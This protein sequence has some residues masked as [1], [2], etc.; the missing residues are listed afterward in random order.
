MNNTSD[1]FIILPNTW[2]ASRS[3]QKNQM[4]W[5]L[6]TPPFTSGLKWLLMSGE[7][8]KLS[9]FPNLCLIQL[10]LCL[11]RCFIDSFEFNYIAWHQQLMH[12]CLK[13]WCITQI[14]TTWLE[15]LPVISL[16]FF[17]FFLCQPLQTKS[18]CNDDFSHV[19]TLCVWGRDYC[20]NIFFFNISLIITLG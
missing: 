15:C 4:Q 12:L 10:I 7:L 1:N 9:S 11:K 13:E 19:F 18:L 17:L 16:N 20:K 8:Q 6:D 14:I 3:P 5:Q 2:E